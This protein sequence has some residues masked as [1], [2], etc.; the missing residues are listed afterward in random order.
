MMLIRWYRFKNPSMEERKRC[1]P[2][3]NGRL[4]SRDW[5][6]VSA[7]PDVAVT[8]ATQSL[9]GFCQLWRLM[10]TVLLLLIP[11]SCRLYFCPG[12]DPN[13]EQ[14]LQDIFPCSQSNR[15]YKAVGLL[16][17]GDFPKDTAHRKNNRSHLPS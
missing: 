2:V 5:H 14:E 17:E 4:L 16:W 7:S 6:K 12:V 15:G 10:A 11:C 1:N 8:V 13:E 9:Q 3:C